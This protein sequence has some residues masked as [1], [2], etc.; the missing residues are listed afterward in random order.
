MFDKTNTLR[1]ATLGAVAIAALASQPAL[2]QSAT[3]NLAVSADVTENCV[4]STTAIAFG[5]VDVTSGANVDGTGGLS[6][7]CTSGT[8]WSATAG[9]GAG[10]GATNSVRKMASGANLLNYALYTNSARTTL[11]GDGDADG[12]AFTGTGSGSAQAS[13]I[14]G[15]VPSGQSS[16]P[17]GA[18]ADTVVVTVTY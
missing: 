5:N 7:T 4:V 15:R 9:A 3:D 11:W 2:A 17:A 12:A 14:Y 10:T 13:I 6:V 8:I 18:Y 16:V 1:L